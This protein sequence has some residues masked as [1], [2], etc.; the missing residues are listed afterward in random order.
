MQ[1][2]ATTGTVSG[3]FS[4]ALNLMNVSG[5]WDTGELDGRLR[6]TGPWSTSTITKPNGDPFVLWEVITVGE[7]PWILYEIQEDSNGYVYGVFFYAVSRLISTNVNFPLPSARYSGTF[8]PGTPTGHNQVDAKVQVSAADVNGGNS[9]TTS[10]PNPF[11][12]AS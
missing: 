11:P 5:T 9:V 10:S 3:T 6:L 12:S 1:V 8:I 4:G 7:V 2:D